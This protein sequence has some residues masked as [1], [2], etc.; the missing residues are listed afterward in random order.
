M[1]KIGL[2]CPTQLTGRPLQF[3]DDWRDNAACLRQD[4]ALFFDPKTVDAA[5]AFC[6]I[7]TVRT[8]C[9]T[10]A[11]LYGETGVR[12]GKTEQEREAK[13]IPKQIGSVRVEVDYALFFDDV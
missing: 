5:L 8:E 13:T 6:H 4:P 11:L 7:C 3:I 9:L 12:G 1:V 10:D 2:K